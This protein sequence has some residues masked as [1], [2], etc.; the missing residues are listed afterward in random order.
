MPYT[1]VLPI[2]IALF[3]AVL[4]LACLRF[5]RCQRFIAVLGSATLL[6][7]A[8]WLF[9]EVQ[10]KGILSIN[11]GNWPAP[12]GISL[13]ADLLSA[14]LVLVTAS[15]GLVLTLYSLASID[16]PRQRY[17]YYPLYYILIAG[18]CGAFLTGDLFNLYVFFEVMLIASFVL[19]ALGGER[20]QLEGA[21][22]YVVMN[23]VASALF[24]VGVGLIYG[25]LGTLNMA[26]IA[27]LAGSNSSHLVNTA[28]TL[29][30]I[31]FSV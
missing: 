12:Y 4:C 21:V 22:K 7:A 30:L 8:I 9:I 13:V 25:Q 5:I 23:L 16:R 15:I 19:L 14:T 27:Q 18:V 29:L 28:S 20:N 10:A 3:T 11:I 24:L 2:I 1:V 26:H 17:G 6:G 31:A